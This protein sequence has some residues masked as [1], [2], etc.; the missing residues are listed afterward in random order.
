MKLSNT[1][2]VDNLYVY[3]L[4]TLFCLFDAGFYNPDTGEWREF[5]I[6]QGKN[7]LFDLVKFYTDS[8]ISYL[9]GYN[10]LSFDMQV[11]EFILGNYHYWLELSN[12]EICQTIYKFV[13]KLIED[14]N[15]NIPVPYAEYKSKVRQIDVFKILHFDNENKRT[16]LKACQVTMRWKDVREMPIP[17]N[18]QTISPEQI[19]EVIYYRRNDVLSTN[20]VFNYVLGNTDNINYKGKNKLEDR[21]NMMEEENLPC[22][23]WNDVKIGEESNLKDY[24]QLSK[25]EKK[26]AFPKNVKQPH[27]MYFKSFF[28][29]T[30][31]FQSDKVKTF[32]E[33]FGNTK[34]LR[35]KQT[36]SIN[37]GNNTITVAKGGLHSCEGPRIL[38]SNDQFVII[39]CDIGLVIWPN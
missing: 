9:V 13:Q 16:S 24:L 5:Q 37:L 39:Q 3:D 1:I 14:S 8:K 22:L 34:V 4:E 17:H 32:V 15:Y 33:K 20:E 38:K 31:T 10:S 6:H 23:N 26:Q 36:F 2:E 27:G 19:E 21:F 35:E 30:V 25:R 12:L 18:I 7:D 28:P 11:M 29:D